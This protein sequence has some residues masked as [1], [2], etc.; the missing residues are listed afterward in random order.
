MKEKILSFLNSNWTVTLVATTVG[1]YLGI[2]MNEHYSQK[3]ERQSAEQAIEDVLLEIQDNYQELVKWD[4]ISQRNYDFFT[5]IN[6]YVIDLDE[7]TLIMPPQKR[8]SISTEFPGFLIVTDSTDQKDGTF[9][10]H[11]SLELEFYSSLVFT[12]HFEIAWSAMKNT[13][14]IRYLDFDCIK[15]I[16]F[17]YKMFDYSNEARKKWLTVFIGKDTDD[18]NLDKT[19][20]DWASENQ[21]NQL[22]IQ[23]YEKNQALLNNCG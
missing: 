12:P 16:N 15:A 18:E 23:W 10:Y 19:I 13:E 1:V 5:L 3:A 6:Q 14:Y 17:F 21:V 7:L 11:G 4:S 2:F 20:D 9:S 8:D 22:L